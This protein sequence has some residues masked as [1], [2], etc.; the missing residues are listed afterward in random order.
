MAIETILL[1]V[2]PGDDDRT[3]EL[4]A[5]VADVARPTDSRVVILHV[6]TQD[7]YDDVVEQLDFGEPAGIDQVDVVARQHT[8]IQAIQRMLDNRGVKWEIRGAVGP[9]GERIVE[10]AEAVDAD[11]VFVGGRQ[12]SPTGKAIF[13]STAQEVMLNAP[14][15]VTFVRGG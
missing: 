6:F 4:G 14:A 11:M 3:E 10:T 9:H 2:G 1:A 12:R 8:T 7:E 5:A 15:P 13:G